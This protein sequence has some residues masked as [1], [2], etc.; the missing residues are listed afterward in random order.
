MDRWI[1]LRYLDQRV[2]CVDI[3]LLVL[4]N[5]KGKLAMELYKA[6]RPQ[7]F[8]DVIGQDE[9]VAF[10]SAK[11]KT[12]TLPHAILFHGGSGCGKTTLARILANKLKCNVDA[13]LSEINVAEQRGIERVRDIKTEMRTSP[14]GGGFRVYIL[15]EVHQMSR[16]GQSALLKVLEDGPSHVYFFLCTTD[17]NKLI[18][19]IRTRCSP[20]QCRSLTPKELCG[21]VA[22]VV[23]K[24]S[25]DS[26]TYPPD[27][28]IEKIAE[29]AD[30]SARMAVQLLEKVIDLPSA[31]EQLTSLE[32]SKPEIEKKAID[33]CRAMMSFKP[34]W[35]EI[36]K[37]IGEITEDPEAIRW[38]V[39]GYA[40][41]VLLKGGKMAGRAFAILCS[42]ESNFYDSKKNG[43]VRACWEVLGSK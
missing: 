25:K 21:V 33:L 4:L 31:D 23:Q 14:L 38:A 26:S 30:G 3:D 35:A 17:P 43:L 8:K 6:H 18:P 2:C 20:V 19:T 16:D 11:L 13:N 7:R 22:N 12:N 32:N 9:A 42:F 15:D 28:V 34:S 41:S 27:E 39:M 5:C 10:L 24:H 40:S 1:R 36:A 29:C 37:L